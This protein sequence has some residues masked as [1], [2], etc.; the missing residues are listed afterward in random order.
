MWKVTWNKYWGTRFQDT[1]VSLYFTRKPTNNEI[2]QAFR[3][4]GHN[5][6]ARWHEPGCG[7]MISITQ[8]KFEF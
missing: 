2:T 8:L 7:G 4:K 5:L 1:F 6:F 3:K